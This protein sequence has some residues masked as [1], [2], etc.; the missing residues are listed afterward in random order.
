[1]DYYIIYMFFDWLPE[2]IIK[3]KEL[4]L[5]AF[6]LVF[7][8]KTLIGPRVREY[9]KYRYSNIEEYGNLDKIQQ[10]HAENEQLENEIELTERKGIIANEEGVLEGVPVSGILD[11]EQTF[12]AELFKKWSKNIFTY[13]QLGNEKDLER[14]KQSVNEELIDKRIRV[15]Q[16]FEEDNLELKREDL[17]V[18]EIK[19]YDYSRGLG[20][21]QIQ[22]CI[23]S[24][25][26]EYVMK[27][28]TGRV[29]VG[30]KRKVCMKNYLLT[31]Q[32]Q[33]GKEKEGFI[34]NCP[35]CGATYADTEF[36]VCQYCG[37]LV[38]PIRYNWKLIKYEII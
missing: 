32:K 10:Y 30:S 4:I 27:K 19:I 15:L 29:V 22:I 37:G 17:L 38:N 18:E 28:D 36:G 35:S 11:D 9:I 16:D 6:L 3:Y 13:L 31:F 7:V 24:R 21:A 5:V 2:M 25:F 20:K 23:K 34:S 26:K 14:I 8:W 33:A 1:M 12:D